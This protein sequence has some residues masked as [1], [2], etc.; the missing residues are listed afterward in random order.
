MLAAGSLIWT[1]GATADDTS[2]TSSQSAALDPTLA[3]DS[4]DRYL[5][6]YRNEPIPNHTIRIEA[7]HYSTI[8]GMEEVLTDNGAGGERGALLTDEAGSVQW[9]FEVAEA[10]LYRILVRYSNTPGKNS[11]IERELRIDGQIP[12]AEASSIFFQRAWRN[13]AEQIARD[14]R[15]NDL[16]PAQKEA[17]VWSEVLLRDITGY[18]AEPYLFYFSKGRHT[19]SFTSLKEP[20]AIDWI[21]LTQTENPVDYSDQLDIYKQNGYEAA[22]DVFIKLQAEDAVLKSNSTLYPIYDRSPTVEPYHVSKVRMNAIGG[23]NWRMPG[24]WIEWE[25]EVPEDGLY[26]IALKS[27]QNVNRGLRSTRTL[28]ID[29]KIPFTEAAALSFPYSSDWQMHVL[30]SSEEEP[31]L[32]YLEKGKHRLRL[33]VTLGELAPVL[34][35]VESIVLDLNALYRKII[36]FTGVEPD[37]YRDYQLSIRIPGLI[38][39]LLALRDSIDRVAESLEGMDGKVSD[40]TAL[41]QKL[42]IQLSS[43]AEK[44]DTIPTRLESFKTNVGSLSTWMMEIKEQPLVI[45]YLLVTSPGAKLPRAGATWFETV[46]HEVSAFFASFF[47]DYNTFDT[48]EGAAKTVKVW[49]LAGRDQAQILKKLIDNDFSVHHDIAIELQL[50]S[51][52]VL[53]SAT[54]A[55]KGPDVAVQVGNDVPVNFAMRGALQDLSVFSDFDEIVRQFHPS[56]M[57]P[58]EYLGGYYALPEQ[59]IFPMLFYRKDILEELGLTVPQTWD[60]IYAMIPVLQKNNLQFGLPQSTLDSAQVTDQLPPN[61]TYAML[62]YQNDGELYRNGGMSSAL[63]S[64]ESI[65]AFQKWTELFANYK[66]PI[67][68]DFPN[69]FRTG[70]MPIGIAEYTTY[71]HLSVSAPEIRGLWDIAP[72]PGTLAEN[73]E[74][75]RDVSSRGFGVVMFKKTEHKEAAWEFM[76][77]W[78]SQE[79]Q[80][81]FGREIEGLLGVSARYPTANLKAFEQLPWSSADLKRFKEQWDWVRAN[82]EVPGGY[83]TGR[84]LDNAYRRVVLQ[85][86]D[87]RETIDLYVRYVNDE[88]AI[89]RKEF[90][91]PTEK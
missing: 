74:I 70:E 23:L 17:Q 11:E 49:V 15:G 59:Q 54:L 32:F 43:M 25:I 53:L 52:D 1:G 31:Y 65:Q 76:K 91:L 85:G 72:V 24:Q 45:D 82:P 10:G 56:A 51:A 73:G 22:E 21:E 6:S 38:D 57:V 81:E 41:L 20:M 90:G 5:E 26:Q 62:L 12:F 78:T 35:T 84:H 69:R 8:D 47:E 77:W 33:E 30:S 44:P 86:D 36:S 66:L 60:D 29:G 50:V 87:P 27:K 4:Y 61:P 3:E 42:S 46:K 2:E 58:Y 48:A 16:R 83:F 67:I 7:E 80:T 75:R 79:I 64:E 19:L 68:Y 71:N 28:Y 9:E 55:G 39:E 89:K 18:Y 14:K 37:P 63:D 34:R 13:E 88:I 40:R